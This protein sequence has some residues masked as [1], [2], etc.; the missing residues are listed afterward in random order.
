MSKYVIAKLIM[1]ALLAIVVSVFNAHI[2]QRVVVVGAFEAS[3]R[4]WVVTIRSRNPA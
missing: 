1:S 2:W 4:P 3:P